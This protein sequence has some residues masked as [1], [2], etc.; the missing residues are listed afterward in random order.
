MLDVPN[1]DNALPFFRQVL[2][3]PVPLQQ[4]IERLDVKRPNRIRQLSRI[5]YEQKSY[6]EA[7]ELLTSIVQK[8]LETNILHAELYLKSQQYI[9]AWEILSQY[10]PKNCTLARASAKSLLH[11]GERKKSIKYY[12]IAMDHC[13]ATPGL[14]R[15]LL[16]AKLLDGDRQATIEAEILLREKKKNT[17][18]RR[19]L[20]HALSINDEYTSMLPHLN[21]LLEQGKI[22]DLERDDIKRIQYGLPIMAYPLNR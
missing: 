19:L 6:R 12:R 3:Y 16:I 11:I 1:N 7:E 18:I 13:G 2:K 20:L 21:I 5:L 8:D 15:Q 4:T 17:R 10:P 22:T 9:Q 14:Q